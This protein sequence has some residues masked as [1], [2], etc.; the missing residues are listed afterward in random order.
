VLFLL[1]DYKI[2][3]QQSAGTNI[4]I[5]DNVISNGLTAG[6]NIEILGGVIST[7]GLAT[8]TQVSSNTNKLSS[9]QK[10]VDSSLDIFS[11]GN[12]F[13][14]YNLS[15]TTISSGQNLPFNNESYDSQR[16]YNT[17]TYVYTI[18]IAGT[19]LF[20]F[21]WYVVSGSTATINLFRKRSGTAVV[22]QQS[23]NGTAT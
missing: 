21:G 17:T 23:T 19:Y 18:E 15:S 20:T 8:T 5:V 2:N 6:T 9:I 4:S 12:S 10:Q 7:T 13:R 22:I 3:C 16:T 1:L 14:A 11:Q